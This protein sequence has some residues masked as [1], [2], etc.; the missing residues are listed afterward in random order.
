MITDTTAERLRNGI[1]IDGECWR[2]TG[3]RNPQ[4]YGQITINGKRRSA[5]RTAYETWTGEIPEGLHI[6]HLCRVRDC[7]NPAHLEAVTPLENARRA[8]PFR[9]KAT[10]CGHGHEFT[11]S[12]IKWTKRRGYWIRRCRAC[13]NTDRRRTRAEK[14]LTRTPISAERHRENSRKGARVKWERFYQARRVEPGSAEAG[15]GS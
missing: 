13:H 12:N 10:H 6:D 2:W 11:P 7:I 5:H 1:V 15:G 9:K 3:A 8:L 14:A 4:G